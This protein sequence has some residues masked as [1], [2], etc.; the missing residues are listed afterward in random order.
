MFPQS[1]VLVLK[2]VRVITGIDR[3]FKS[4]YTAGN[5]FSRTA[6]FC[7]VT[8]TYESRI[9]FYVTICI[10]PTSVEIPCSKFVFLNTNMYCCIEVCVGLPLHLC[11]Y[12]L[13]LSKLRIMRRGGRYVSFVIR[14]YLVPATEGVDERIIY[15]ATYIRNGQKD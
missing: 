2:R 14:T 15:W 10:T 3:R 9:T 12:S 8:T 11:W 13:K 1:I 4:L 7:N 6:Y 5:N